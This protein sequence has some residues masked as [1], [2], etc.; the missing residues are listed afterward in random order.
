MTRPD[1]DTEKKPMA[2]YLHIPFCKRKCEYCDF[3]SFSTAGTAAQA[4]YCAAL[5][6]EIAQAGMIYGGDFIINT[7]FIG[8]G[9]PSFILPGHIEA[10]TDAVNKAFEVAPDAEIS[11]EM[12]PGTLDMHGGNA[13]L[14]VYRRSGINRISIGLQTADDRALK[15]IGRIHT[16]ADFIRTYDMVRASGFDNVN[17]DLMSALP[18]QSYAGYMASLEQTVGLKPEHLSCYSLIL[19]EGTPL[20]ERRDSLVLPDEDTERKM[21]H[22]T[23]SVLKDAGYVHYEIS[24][25]AWPGYECRHNIAY[26]RRQ[27]YLGL[28]LGAS[29]CVNE[30]RWKEPSDMGSY[31]RL[32]KGKGSDAKEERGFPF[33]PYVEELQRLTEKDRMEETFFVGLRMMEGIST[34]AFRTAFGRTVSEV[35][36]KLPEKLESEGLVTLRDGRIALTDYGVDVSNYVMA[37]FL[38]D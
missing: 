12:N 14:E 16:F 4:E 18:G 22:D 32:T 1:T 25:F 8:G 6:R 21:Y 11:M 3:L 23:V 35:Y 30:I 24:N 33:R 26:W 36:G 9:T 27:D 20:Y 34:E 31:I 17:I 5:C 37:Q 19:E 2:L 38:M 29:S 15:A 13:A 28:G 7:V 10:I